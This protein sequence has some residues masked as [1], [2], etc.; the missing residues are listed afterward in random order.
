M[1]N[2]VAKRPRASCTNMSMVEA[3][4]GG[5]KLIIIRTTLLSMPSEVLIVSMMINALSSDTLGI[6]YSSACF[7]STLLVD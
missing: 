3:A 7:F 1:D 6:D 2:L 5:I 4:L